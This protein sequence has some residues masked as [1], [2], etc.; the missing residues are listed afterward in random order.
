MCGNEGE[1]KEGVGKMKMGSW[2][3]QSRGWRPGGDEEGE[4]WK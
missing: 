2:I 4:N 3:V 1:R